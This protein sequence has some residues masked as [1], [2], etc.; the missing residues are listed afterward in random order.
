MKVFRIMKY[1]PC[2]R[3]KSFCLLKLLLYLSAGLSAI[4]LPC[5][6]EPDEVKLYTLVEEV[7]LN[8]AVFA[9][10][11]TDT[12]LELEVYAPSGRTLGN[13]FTWWGFHDGD[14]SGAQSGNVWKFRLLVDEPGSWTVHARFID[15]GTGEANGPSAKFHYRVVSQA[16]ESSHGHVRIDPDNPMRFA[17]DDGTP[18]VPLSMH[19][20]SLLD[21]ADFAI[22]REWIDQHTRLGV[23][24]MGVRFHSEAAKS[25]DTNIVHFMG[26]DGERTDS[27][28][29]EDLD[30]TRFDVA[31][32]QHNERVLRYAYGK[33]LRLFFWFGISGKNRQYGSYGP[34]DHEIKDGEV[35]L[36]VK[37][38]LFIRYFLARWACY[39]VFWHWTVDSEWEETGGPGTDNQKFQSA[40]AVALRE[41]NPWRTLISNHSLR[42]WRLGGK[43]R[44]WD[45]ATL[46][47]RIPDSDEQVAS[48]SRQFI[49]DND[50]FGIPVFNM[51][52]VWE[53]STVVRSRIATISHLIA[54]GF[55]H[56]AYFP[57]DEESGIPHRGSSWAADWPT[58]NPQ[59][60]EDAEMLGML[61][62]F[63]NRP[64]LLFNSFRPE[65][66]LA[67][68]DDGNLILC[69]ADPGEAYFLWLNE[70]GQATLN[71][72]GVPGQFSV[73]RYRGSDLP[74]SG[75]GELLG[76]VDGGG[77]VKLEKSPT[78]GFGND[79][80]YL[81]KTT[82]PYP[83][84]LV[85]SPADGDRWAS[86]G[87]AA[88]SWK[89]RG[90]SGSVQIEL[91]TDEGLS[92]DTLANGPAEGQAIVRV[93]D[94]VGSALLRVV[95]WD[96]AT[97]TDPI[98]L[99]V[100]ERPDREAPEIKII[101]FEDGKIVGS[102]FSIG[103][104]ALDSSGLRAVE[105]R[106]G[107]EDWRIADG[108]RSWRMDISGIPE[109][110][111][112][113]QIR[114]RDA[115]TPANISEPV[116]RQIVVDSS[117]PRVSDIQVAL[118]SNRN[119][120]VTWTTSEPAESRVQWGI[121]SGVYE[122]ESGVV[123]TGVTEHRVE[124]R[125]LRPGRTHYYV[126]ITSDAYGNAITTSE[127][128]L[129]VPA[130]N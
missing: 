71:L 109:G 72:S 116:T 74:A 113:L 34:L 119:A 95:G 26:I 25:G 118:G 50:H 79:W 52:G 83:S 20:S 28:D 104:T 33:G 27:T 85:S 24:A 70:G 88:V 12:V 18:F 56:I 9:N 39:P 97:V 49:E 112:K 38:Q 55:S 103:G 16:A 76:T 59:H 61:A 32:W 110:E 78:S 21:R 54:G 94:A 3:V 96:E 8:D 43:E 114:A 57:D 2:S 69:L 45:I 29:S 87:T 84:V 51:E 11:F 126:I 22:S 41:L 63:F 13:R 124:M 42:D 15:P 37:Q 127:Q 66:T 111:H 47:K 123:A 23:N 125:R 7:L 5:S 89:S 98:P 121:R 1:L 75:G 92:W 30:Y 105:W 14:G 46:Q 48:A 31:T 128:V 77:L 82:A 115:A 44:G 99:S 73:I 62:R 4:G 100:V 129:H 120:F 93:P 65:H 40:Y 19:G 58:V 122:G 17:F 91:S 86:G 10:P 68:V 6:P 60:R 90:L 36:G 35:H 102:F 64:D 81:L 107:K 53:L 130:K 80:F 67:T 106:I 117:P 101:G 108:L